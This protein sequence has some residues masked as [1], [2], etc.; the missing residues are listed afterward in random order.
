M[1]N[2]NPAMLKKLSL[3]SVRRPCEC[4]GPA[5]GH[6]VKIAG[7]LFGKRRCWRKTETAFK[8]NR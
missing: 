6:G 1:A 4:T 2:K 7:R 8:E 3:A 5:N